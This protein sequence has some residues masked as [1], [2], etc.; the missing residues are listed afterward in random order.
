[1]TW[2]PA[3]AKRVESVRYEVRKHISI[4]SRDNTGSKV[5]SLRT[6][7]SY[8]VPSQKSRASKN[9]GDLSGDRAPSGRAMLDGWLLVGVF[10][11]HDVM[12]PSLA[13]R[14]WVQ[15]SERVEGSIALP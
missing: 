8:Q 10:A 1:M 9:R 15:D 13:E 4:Q 5:R 3:L 6:K 11:G 2:V 14:L 7:L 12:V